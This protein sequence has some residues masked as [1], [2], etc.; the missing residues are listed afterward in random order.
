MNT[1]YCPDISLLKQTLGQCGHHYFTSLQGDLLSAFAFETTDTVQTK[2]VL[3]MAK[4][5]SLFFKENANQLS[6]IKWSLSTIY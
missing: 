2:I 1:V 4:F 6:L 5:F 3:V